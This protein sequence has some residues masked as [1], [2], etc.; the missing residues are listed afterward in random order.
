M[1]YD[2]AMRHQQALDP[3][4]LTTIA[5]ALHAID[6]AITDCRNAGKD[7][8]TD[9]AVILLARHLGGVCARAADDTILRRTCIDQIAKIRRHPVLRTLAYRGVGYEDRKSVV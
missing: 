4:A 6:A 1:H 5:A 8:E 7:S 3:S 9:P 2:V